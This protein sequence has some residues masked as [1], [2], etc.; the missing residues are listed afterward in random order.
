VARTLTDVEQILGADALRAR[1]DAA[2]REA[3]GLDRV[4]ARMRDGVSRSAALREVLRGCN[5]ASQLRRLRVYEA[6]GRATLVS[7]RYGPPAPL[8]M[9]PA[10]LEGLRVLAKADPTAGSEILAKRLSAVF[11]ISVSGSV[12]QDAL[13]EM[14]LARPRGRPWWRTAVA[15]AAAA[16][17]A[18]AVEEAPVVEMLALAGAEL[19]KA[20][21]DECGAVAA[22]TAAMEERLASLPTPEGPVEDDRADRDALGRF[23]PEYNEPQ[24]RIEPELGDRFNSVTERRAV[25]DLRE[26][27]VVKESTEVHHRKNLAMMLLPCVVRGS[28]WAGLEHWRGEHLGDLCGFAYQAATLDKYARELKLA[29]CAEASR[30]AVASFWLREEGTHTDPQTGAVMLYADASTKPLWTHHWT[31]ASKVSKTGRVMPA[32]TTMTLHSGAGTP[33]LYRSYSGQVSVPAKVE[34][35]LAEYEKHAGDGT[36]RRVIVIDREAHAVWLFKALDPRW[37]FVIPLRSPVVGP[38]AKFEEVGVWSPYGDGPDEVRDAHLWLNDSRPGEAALRTRVVGRRRH[39]TGK[40]A[41][42]A[43][44]LPVDEF[45]ATDVVRLYFDRWPLQEHVY[46]DG[47]GAV[48]LDV[49]HGYGKRKVE[50]VAVVDRDQ[51]LHGQIRRLETEIA[52]RHAR[53]DDLRADRD[54]HQAALDRAAPY[55]QRDQQVFGEALARGDAPGV[56]R[57]RHTEV[58]I[59]RRWETDTGAKIEGFSRELAK[60]E[61]AAAAADE[62]RTRK[63]AEIEHLASLR[64]IFTVDVELDEILTA[65]KLTFMNL[66]AVL[67]AKYLGTTMELETLIEAVLTLPG[68]RVTTKT[69]E[70]VRIYRRDRDQRT[71]A[72]VERACEQLTLRHL[73]RDDRDLRFEVVAPPPR[74]RRVDPNDP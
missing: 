74:R 15:E 35:F 49:H 62:S 52:K 59:W 3:A 26:M 45:T 5:V 65:F 10:V 29:G 50:T 24:P 48:G 66:C 64:Q 31:R 13:R 57:R 58:E 56:L 14:G 7:R 68:E 70:T 28:R 17:A 22:L 61:Q 41:W 19:L 44:N 69:T 38:S 71:L 16:E 53:A 72:A 37:G 20:V 40:V 36:A 51:K 21:D 43:T 34:Q 8:K 33:L 42:Y 18:P 11:E 6:G 25:K 23:L 12:V 60:V 63:L 4:L 55:N 30:E 67:M 2:D 54:T 73:R 1:E 39:R 46:R 27:R 32:T 47:S 9:T